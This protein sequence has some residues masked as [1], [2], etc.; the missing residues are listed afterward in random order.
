MLRERLRNELDR[1]EIPSDLSPAQPDLPEPTLPENPDQ[2][3]AI[4][5]NARSRGDLGI[6]MRRKFAESRLSGKNERAGF[7]GM[8]AHEWSSVGT[9]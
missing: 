3:V 5:F 8:R 1:M 7:A 6:I 2:P 4:E 9:E